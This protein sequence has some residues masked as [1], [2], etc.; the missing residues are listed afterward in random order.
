MFFAQT[1][2]SN[3]LQGFYKVVEN[4]RD[5]VLIS[6]VFLYFLLSFEF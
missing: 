5:G 4:D 3:S 1:A 2:F 6:E